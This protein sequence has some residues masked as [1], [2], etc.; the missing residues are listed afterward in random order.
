MEESP[1]GKAAGTA[2]RAVVNFFGV[3]VQVTSGRQPMSAILPSLIHYTRSKTQNSSLHR[4]ISCPQTLR[5][6]ICL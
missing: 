6:N 1:L 5:R 2:G 3:G 4:G